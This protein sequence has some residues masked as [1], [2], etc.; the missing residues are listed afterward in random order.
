MRMKQYIIIACA[1]FGPLSAISASEISFSGDWENGL[2]GHGNWKA[3]QVVASNRFQRV[4]DPVRQGRYA[5]RVEVRPGDDPINSSGERSE[6]LVMSDR[7][8]KPINETESSGTQYY[9]FGV[10]LDSKWQSPTPDKNGR[11]ATIFQLH[12]P[13]ALKASPSFAVSVLDHFNIVLHSGDLDSR[14]NSLQWKSYAFSDGSL[15]PGKW[16]DLVIRIKFA[17]DFTGSV[18]VWRRNEG[19]SSFRQVASLENV[20]TLQY[21]SSLGNVGDHYWKHG[22]YCSKQTTITNVLWLDGLTRGD[23]FDDVVRAGFGA[24]NKS[25]TQQTPGGD[26]LKAASQECRSSKENKSVAIMHTL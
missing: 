24:P 22:L 4:T 23:S 21:R 7:R 17:K 19:Q 20:P 13:D 2:V 11:W 10:R 8:G 26:S 18:A 3:L 9:A 1:L 12:G 15:N 25:K 6:V 14:T 16:V 5:A